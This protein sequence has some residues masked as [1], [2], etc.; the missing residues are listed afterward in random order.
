MHFSAHIISPVEING[1]GE[2]KSMSKSRSRNCAWSVGMHALV[3]AALVACGGGGD[4]RGETLASNATLETSAAAETAATAGS[5]TAAQATEAMA[6]SDIAKPFRNAAVL[7]DEKPSAA[8]EL[9]VKA[10]TA[11]AVGKMDEH[12]ADKEIPFVVH[13]APEEESAEISAMTLQAVPDVG[14]VSL[15]AA[16][17]AGGAANAGVVIAGGASVAI[18]QVP[19]GG[20]GPIAIKDPVVGREG[21]KVTIKPDPPAPA[22]GPLLRWIVTSDPQYPWIDQCPGCNELVEGERLVDE[23][24]RS[25]NSYAAG[26]KVDAM[27]INGDLTAFG[28]PW[29]VAV[30]DSKV[31][32]LNVKVFPGLGNHDIQNNAGVCW[33]NQCL[34]RSVYWYDR[35]VRE[36][37]VNQYD[38]TYSEWY[39]FPQI[40]HSLTGSLAYMKEFGN[41]RVL[42]LN[43]YPEYEVRGEGQSDWYTFGAKDKIKISST[44]YWLEH[45]LASARAAGKVVVVMMHK[46]NSKEN[47]QF[48]ALM[49]Q[50]GVTA[51]FAGHVHSQVGEAGPNGGTR[52]FLSG[53]ASYRSYLIVE[54]DDAASKMHVLKVEN[55]DPQAAKRIAS[56]D[57]KSERKS[58]LPRIMSGSRAVEVNVINNGG[59]S[60]Q[61]RLTYAL[62]GRAHEYWA[63]LQLGNQQTWTV[64][65]GARDVYLFARAYTGVLW[66]KWNTIY[67]TPITTESDV[68]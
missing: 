42:Q 60:A 67:N 6:Q 1:T 58:N 37:G 61:Y 56:V 15:G 47:S 50:Y 62:D 52:Q 17:S 29:Q 11:V 19:V 53:S 25:I 36:A 45:Q 35:M 23:Q 34:I 8:D 38:A 43:N 41:V 21:V 9:A 46:P 5:S 18:G 32:S 22:P 13:G 54:F 28:H 3:A 14:G 65:A 63:D 64:P 12:A 49:E 27:F 40:V 57:Y 30:M 51:I 39:E 16:G 26:T 55:N 2:M 31:R 10:E 7:S 59:Y 68:A 66:S 48:G 24:Y 4:S 33:L 20:S 44:L